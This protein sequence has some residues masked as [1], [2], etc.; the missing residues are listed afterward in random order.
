[1]K[2]AQKDTLKKLFMEKFN[3]INIDLALVDENGVLL[4]D[5]IKN[6]NFTPYLDRIVDLRCEYCENWYKQWFEVVEA[7]LD[8][9]FIENKYMNDFGT[10]DLLYT[11]MEVYVSAKYTGYKKNIFAY[12][13]NWKQYSDR[14]F[15]GVWFGYSQFFDGCEMGMIKDG[16]KAWENR[17]PA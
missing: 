10:L 5:H 17:H 1:M 2:Q 13:Y 6:A 11:V 4:E 16:R 12:D 14:E 7:V 3:S 15:I 9:D 8:D